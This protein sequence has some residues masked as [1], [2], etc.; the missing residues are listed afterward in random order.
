ME[1]KI[2]ID[3]IC[4]HCG[5]KVQLQKKR[6]QEQCKFVCPACKHNLH[7]LFNTTTA[8]QMYS[9]FSVNPNE[10]KESSKKDEASNNH[11]ENKKS[12]NIDK[13]KTVYKK[14]NSKPHLYD[15]IPGETEDKP[16]AKNRPTLKDTIYLT[17]KK[18]F[19]L[20]AE[21]YQLSEGR[22]IIGREDA[23]EPSDISLSGDETISR[24]SISVDI[25]ADEFGFDYIMK[26][27]NASN[28][29]LVNGKQVYI[30]EKVYLDFGDIITIGKT[31][32]KFDNK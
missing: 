32:L 16:I 31:N 26:V 30:G 18:M 23:E 21:R 28:P 9:F 4:I 3:V 27:L 12:Q 2:I 20:V 10:H 17:R 19:G 22:T 11:A 29:V 14:D 5:N 1:T 24:R 8:P 25:V 15:Y 7:I 6:S 13:K